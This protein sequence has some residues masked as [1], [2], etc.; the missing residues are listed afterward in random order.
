MENKVFPFIGAQHV[1][2][3]T[4][5]ELL[6]VIRTIESRGAIETAH[7]IMRQCGQAF[8]YGIATGRDTRLPAS[9]RLGD[10]GAG[11]RRRLHKCLLLVQRE[12]RILTRTDAGEGGRVAH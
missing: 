2:S 5:P 11:F 4:A 8:L 3:V 7:T 6:K 9:E 12:R 10:L 1:E